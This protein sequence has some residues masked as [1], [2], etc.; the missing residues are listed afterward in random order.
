M[1]N[2]TMESSQNEIM[3][4]C[5]QGA[6][7]G[8]Q[9]ECRLPNDTALTVTVPSGVQPGACFPVTYGVPTNALSLADRS[10]VFNEAAQLED[11]DHRGTGKATAK[12]E[13]V[14]RRLPPSF[15]GIS[16]NQLKEFIASVSSAIK[17][18]MLTNP[19]M[20]E[21]YR[22]HGHSN[23]Y[24]DEAKFRSHKVGPNMHLVNAKFIL[25]VTE[26]PDPIRGI[27]Y[28]S[29]SV[30]KNSQAG[31]QC[32]L[33][34]SHAWDEGV[35]EFGKSALS[36]WPKGCLG[37]YICFLSNPQHLGGLIS[38]MIQTPKDSPFYKVLA[39]GPRMMIM[40]PNQNTPIHSRLWCVYE[41]HCA[42]RLDI[43]VK[44]A[45]N[46]QALA[47]D[48][49]ALSHVKE[50]KR[51]FR[52]CRALYCCSCG[53]STAA[54]IM[55][56]SIRFLLGLN[57]DDS[58]NEESITVFVLVLISIPIIISACA[59]CCARRGQQSY[60]DMLK[61]QE[62][63]L[64]VRQAQ[65]TMQSDAAAIQREIHGFENEINDMLRSWL[66]HLHDDGVCYARC[67][68]SG[69]AN[70]ES[71]S[72]IRVLHSILRRCRRSGWRFCGS[73]WCCCC[74]CCFAFPIIAIATVIAFAGISCDVNDHCD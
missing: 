37:A 12:A 56:V 48:R 66:W 54:I 34:F 18:N 74:T 46:P 15:W 4:Q 32:D 24:Y 73:W 47:T 40:V 43:P 49:E 62:S 11:A 71:T 27:P 20:D 25:P 70:L 59:W 33:F 64:D 14:H 26:K 31:L 67:S 3:V 17:D 10:R 51:R 45:G 5:P 57:D 16:K 29:Y 22:V 28:L 19:T 21:L 69:Y 36:A 8:T 44:V 35:F 72:G 52:C 61:S 13:E 68:I 41:A 63:T 55:P 9:I 23:F 60:S 30:G 65:C 38:E 53:I 42:K 2:G 39:T 58:S 6:G 50:T 7:P 1:Q